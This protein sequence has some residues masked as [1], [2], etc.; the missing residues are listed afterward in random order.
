MGKTSIATVLRSVS[1]RRNLLLFF[2]NMTVP[3]PAGGDHEMD[4][5]GG[6]MRTKDLCAKIAGT[7]VL[8]KS[9]Y[10]NQCSGEVLEMA[11][12]GNRYLIYRGI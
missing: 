9:S 12:V 6:K 2:T 3:K 8:C 7:Q 10:I 1:K 11:V 5:F 4:I